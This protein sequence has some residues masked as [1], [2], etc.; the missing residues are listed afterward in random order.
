MRHRQWRLGNSPWAG[1]N[2]AGSRRWATD[3]HKGASAPLTGRGRK[4]REGQMQ[5]SHDKAGIGWPGTREDETH[6][7]PPPLSP[8][9]ISPSI[10]PTPLV[11]TRSAGT[12][13]THTT[14]SRKTRICSS[15]LQCW[16]WRRQP[17][18]ST[19]SLPCTIHD[20]KR[21]SRSTPSSPLTLLPNPHPPTSPTGPLSLPSTSKKQWY[22]IS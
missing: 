19:P 2:V 21:T 10:R 14:D 5:C 12:T 11:T 7:W 15:L 22:W 17:L 9:R 3:R 6:P 8:H 20:E 16:C 13:Q 18:L 1:G 4:G